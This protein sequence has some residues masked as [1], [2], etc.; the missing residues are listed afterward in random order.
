M[1]TISKK[2]EFYR[3]KNGLKP[4]QVAM[5]LNISERE[6]LSFETDK[7]DISAVQLIRLCEY[8]EIEIAS[9]MAGKDDRTDVKETMKFVPAPPVKPVSIKK[10][11]KTLK[12]KQ[13]PKTKSFHREDEPEE[14]TGSEEERLLKL[15][16]RIVTDVVLREMEDEEK[17]EQFPNGF[18]Y[19]QERG[20]V[21]CSRVISGERSWYD[22]HGLKC[23]PCQRALES[24]I[25][26]YDATKSK[27]SF[28]TVIQLEHDFG[29]KGKMLRL[30]KKDGTIRSRII[31]ELD[32]KGTY[33][34]IFLLSDNEQFLPPREKLKVG[35]MVK[36][37]NANGSEEF[38]HYPWHCFVDP[39][40]HLKD[41]GISR[42]L[43]FEELSDEKM[44][45]I[46]SDN[47]EAMENTL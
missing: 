1:D 19:D 22:H 16:A 23:M 36:E 6:Y 3:L 30:W 31:P 9:F 21:I 5:L 39:I 47:D 11:T 42:Y 27:D 15:M 18:H 28:Y 25:I 26:P 13:N 32:G 24:G 35:G 29:L 33:F 37:I 45:D 2:L 46:S 8:Y 7:S 17:L 44:P 10:T 43:R 12:S 41:Y 38:V 40:D 20:C 34:E 14:T 4:K